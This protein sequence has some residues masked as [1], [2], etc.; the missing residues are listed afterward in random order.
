MYSIAS[1]FP[2]QKRF[3]TIDIRTG[4]QVNNWMY[5]TVFKTKERAEE[6]LKLILENKILKDGVELKVLKY[7]SN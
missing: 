1:K 2:D 5:C 4:T 7:Q 6:V 3:Y